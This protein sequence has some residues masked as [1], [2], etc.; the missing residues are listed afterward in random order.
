MDKLDILRDYITGMSLT[1]WE[2]GLQFSDEHF[3]YCEIIRVIDM[4]KDKEYPNVESL[5]TSLQNSEQYKNAMQ[6][7]IQ[8]Q[9]EFALNNEILNKKDIIEDIIEYVE[10]NV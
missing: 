10:K 1:C 2:G 6:N 8:Q 5:I 7:I 4:L 9:I 3:A